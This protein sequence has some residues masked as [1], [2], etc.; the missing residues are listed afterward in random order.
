MN[1][2]GINNLKTPETE[3][4][5][6]NKKYVDEKEVPI[7]N[8]ITKLNNEFN[9]HVNAFSIFRRN[10]N[11]TNNEFFGTPPTVDIKLIDINA[12]L[13]DINTKIADIN[14]GIPSIVEKISL[15]KILH[16]QIKNIVYTIASGS[17]I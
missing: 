8:E 6:V 4:D 12:K 9:G 14:S 1:N 13:A 3:L 11:R 5:A 17:G 15:V 10:V 7:N 16:Q 2:N